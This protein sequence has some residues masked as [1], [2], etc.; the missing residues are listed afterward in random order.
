MLTDS[1]SGGGPSASGPSPSTCHGSPISR[2]RPQT[3]CS[4]PVKKPARLEM[5]VVDQIGREEH[6]RGGHARRLQPIGQ[7]RGPVAG[8]ERAERVIEGGVVGPPRLGRGE[9]AVVELGRDS[10]GRP[11][12]RSHWASEA[13]E[14]ATHDAGSAAG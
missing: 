5:R 3:G 11:S 12:A 8:R 2:R 9:A 7:R 10:R 13:T 4:T 1:R 6:G 14:N